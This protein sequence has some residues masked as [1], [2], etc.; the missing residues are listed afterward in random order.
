MVG[1][2]KANSGNGGQYPSERG[3][4]RGGQ[5]H[6]SKRKGSKRAKEGGMDPSSRSDK[7]DKWGKGKGSKAFEPRPQFK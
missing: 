1:G 3:S 4:E 7:A 5:A 2:I 6:G